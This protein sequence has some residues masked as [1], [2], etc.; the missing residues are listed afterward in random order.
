MRSPILS[1]HGCVFLHTHTHKKKRTKPVG[2]LSSSRQNP[3]K[4]KTNAK[5]NRTQLASFRL[6][7]NLKPS[8]VRKKIKK[9]EPRSEGLAAGEPPRAAGG[10]EAGRVKPGVAPGTFRRNPRALWAGCK[11]K[12]ITFNQTKHV[13]LG[14]VLG[15]VL[16]F[17]LLTSSHPFGRPFFESSNHYH[18]WFGGCVT[19]DAH[20][21]AHNLTFGSLLRSHPSRQKLSERCSEQTTLGSIKVRHHIQYKG[22]K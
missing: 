19:H 1:I 14:G 21:R 12:P 3:T 8:Q 10:A 13:F 9:D 18:R 15:L 5:M 4:S 6:S 17:C 11:G 7:F 20:I 16:G 22:P 2:F